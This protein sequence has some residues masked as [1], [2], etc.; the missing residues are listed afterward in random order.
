MKSQ[1]RYKMVSPNKVQ[2]FPI[3]ESIDSS[4]VLRICYKYHVLYRGIFS[5][6]V[7]ELY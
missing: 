2:K 6:I 3:L 1:Y 4:V 7:H 5:L